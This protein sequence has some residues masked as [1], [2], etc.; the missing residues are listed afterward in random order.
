M[1]PAC[2]IS[3]ATI[4]VKGASVV[5]LSLKDNGLVA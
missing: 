5:A 3:D 2:E 1:F 4:E